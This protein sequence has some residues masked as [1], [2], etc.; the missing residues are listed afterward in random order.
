MSD[1]SA[2]ELLRPYR[3]ETDGGWSR[4]EATH[5]LWRTQVGASAAEIDAALRDGPEKTL[6]RQ[7]SPQPESAPFQSAEALLRQ[8]ARDTGNIADLKAWWLYRLLHSANPLAEK[9]SLLWHSH[10]ATSNAKVQSALLMGAQND[11]IRR[12]ALGNFR[13]LLQGMA[14]DVAMLIWLDGNAN[15]KRQ[16]NE[17][18]ARE[19]MELF[20]LDVGNYT[21]QDIQEAARAFSGWQVRDGAFWFNPLQHDA[22]TKTVLGRTG[23]LNGDD[24]VALCLA[25]EAC[26]R[27]LAKKLLRGLVLDDPSPNLIAPLAQRIRDHDFQMTPVLR[28][29]L[30]SRLFYSP[31]ARRTLIK[32]PVE[33]VLGGLRTLAGRANLAAAIPLLASLGQDFFEPPTVKGWDGGRLWINSTSLLQRANFAAELVTG[34][35]LGSIADPEQTV[36]QRGL[37]GSQA[38]VEHYVELL[39]NTPAEPALTASLTGALREMQGSYGQQLRGLV[40]L[41]MTMPE[42][43]LM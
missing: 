18:F 14:R 5:L 19:V 25:Q 11:L 34:N 21:E 8:T 33:L 31:L 2:V 30:S 27:F 24:V 20:S 15:R 22:G 12:H 13:D 1:S 3:P 6:E 39:L 37:T 7:L 38:I 42:F 23:N 36:A 41:I 17:N 10:F 26:P 35:R 32:S 29:L 4:R 43:Q 40:Q 28:E 16:P 9:L